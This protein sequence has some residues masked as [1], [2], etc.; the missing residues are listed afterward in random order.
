MNT[1]HKTALLLILSVVSLGMQ[2]QIMTSSSLTV[3]RERVEKPP[4]VV[5]R[6]FQHSVELNQSF[7]SDSRGMFTYGAEYIGGYR[8]NNMFYVGI[9]IGLDIIHDYNVYRYE[10]FKDQSY[11]DWQ[12]WDFFGV[13]LPL[14]IDGR[15][16]FGK[17]WAKP[18]IG[19]SL[20]GLFPFAS[21]DDDAPYFQ[22]EPQF[23]VDFIMK[24]GN[25]IYFSL[26]Y[27]YSYK[28][29]PEHKS[30]NYVDK[31]YLSHVGEEIIH[32]VYNIHSFS[33]H[34]GYTFGTKIKKLEIAR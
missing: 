30:W 33:F 26:A 14:H 5:E 23:G 27:N 8:F 1:L 20:G 17:K 7:G 6:G 13:G 9:G 24:S 2:A 32:R 25:S 10:K 11:F 34:I 16:Y 18:Y 29:Q 12:C 28:N 3:K 15:A 4:V 19:L 31:Y 22:L 21:V